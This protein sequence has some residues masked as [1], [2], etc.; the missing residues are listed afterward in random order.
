M[1]GFRGNKRRGSLIYGLAGVIVLTGA[2]VGI[3]LD[4]SLDGYRQA[5]QLEARLRSAAAIE[6][7]ARVVV[8]TGDQA[9]APIELTGTRVIFS[10]PRIEGTS[11]FL[12]AKAEVRGTNGAVVYTAEQVI[13]YRGESGN[14]TA[15]GVAP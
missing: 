14:W 10:A 4:R 1:T 12:P 2:L 15:L 6:G 9:P 3:V 13:E 8:P 5:V 7:A 11:L